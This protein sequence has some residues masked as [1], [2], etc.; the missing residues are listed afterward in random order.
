MTIDFNHNEMQI[1][2]SALQK[3]IQ[4]LMYNKEANRNKPNYEE[5]KYD[6]K[7]QHAINL[8]NKLSFKMMENVVQNRIENNLEEE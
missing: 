1:L 7:I 3:R 4:G 8:Y 6:D 5:E 2:S